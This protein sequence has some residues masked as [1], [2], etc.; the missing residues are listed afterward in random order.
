MNGLF[1][2]EDGTEYLQNTFKNKELWNLVCQSKNLEEKDKQN[3]EHSLFFRKG[4]KW[5]QSHNS[6]QSI[7]LNTIFNNQYRKNQPDQER[8]SIPSSRKKRKKDKKK[9]CQV[10]RL[11]I[12]S[13]S[14]TPNSNIRELKQHS[15]RSLFGRSWTRDISPP[16][17]IP[18]ET[19][20]TMLT[21]DPQNLF[22]QF[23]TFWKPQDR[24]NN[25]YSSMHSNGTENNISQ[26][27]RSKMKSK[28]RFEG[29]DNYLY[30]KF[31]HR[32]NSKIQRLA[33]YLIKL[34]YKDRHNIDSQ[35]LK[36][37]QLILEN[38]LK[39]EILEDPKYFENKF[40]PFF[41]FRSNHSKIDHHRKLNNIVNCL[42]ERGYFNQKL[43][44][45]Q[46]RNNQ[47][48]ST[49][50]D[51][52]QH[53]FNNNYQQNFDWKQWIMPWL[54]SNTYSTSRSGIELYSSDEP[55]WLEK[56]FSF[57]TQFFVEWRDLM[58]YNRH[59][60]DPK[61]SSRENS[62]IT[63]YTSQDNIYDMWR[64][65]EQEKQDYWKRV[66]SIFDNNNHQLFED[67]FT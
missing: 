63:P 61:L 54:Y 47:G 41:I 25:R 18:N 51:V 9:L 1:F 42:L 2:K 40:L 67:P 5:S 59:N 36:Y 29:Q 66:S 38:Q 55:S 37:N 21:F 48:E 12:R 30:S 10:S 56:S 16:T 60:F 19:D 3:T 32:I 11:P 39:L 58:A 50:V 64:K 22:H 14:V 46:N 23:S 62:W 20:N 31:S 4:T 53:Q 13:P 7:L 49:P 65:D 6:E 17:S 57:L 26:S 45:L 8:H 24:T 28:I 33:K 34:L 27:N 52:D 44:S 35:K 15:H 43:D